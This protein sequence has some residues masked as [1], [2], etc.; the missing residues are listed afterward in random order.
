MCCSPSLRTTATIDLT[1][2]LTPEALAHLPQTR[3]DCITKTTTEGYWATAIPK[4]QF[5]ANADLSAILKIAAD[6]DPGTLKIASP[7]L[8]LQGTADDTVL[9]AWTDTT[10][11]SLC[12]NGTRVSYKVYPGATHETIVTAA[13]ADI[14][15][16]VDARFARK[17]PTG[18]CADLAK[19]AR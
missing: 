10:V 12:K 3:T 11:R 15:A 6:N 16:F 5:I 19:A 2:I 18:D 1:K 7:T 4:D 8:V 17:K 14:R 13:A 9:P